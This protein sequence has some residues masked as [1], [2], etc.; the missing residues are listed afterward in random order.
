[1][2]A[3]VFV[4]SISNVDVYGTEIRWRIESRRSQSQNLHTK[5]KIWM[6]IDY[7]LLTLQ[8]RARYWTFCIEYIG[9]VFSASDMCLEFIREVIHC[10]PISNLLLFSYPRYW[11]EDCA[12]LESNRNNINTW[13]LMLTNVWIIL[14]ITIDYYDQES[15]Q[16]GLTITELIGS[17]VDLICCD[18]SASM[19]KHMAVSIQLIWMS[20][21]D[22]KKLYLEKVV[23]RIPYRIWRG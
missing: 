4:E 5:K 13:I 9:S 18:D 7:S 14:S 12:M 19:R 21:G 1:M 23:Q 11:F 10:L 22:K 16:N 20:V 2:C 17:V 6:E 15:G 8:G 3:C